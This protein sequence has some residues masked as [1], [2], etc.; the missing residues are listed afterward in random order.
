MKT[1]R[2]AV[3]LIL[4][5]LV[6]A[7]VQGQ[8]NKQTVGTLLGAGTGALLGSQFGSGKGQL[9]MVAIGAL[10][11]AFLGSEIGKSLDRADR[12]MAARAQNVALETGRS[13]TSTTWVNPDSGHSGRVTPRPSYQVASGETCR[14]Y[15]HVVTIDGRRETMKGTACRQRDGTWRTI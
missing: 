2:F 3:I 8:G 12:Q 5:S 13:G 14:E 4:V 10:G 1:S 7:C 9:A 11:G 15:E 6:S